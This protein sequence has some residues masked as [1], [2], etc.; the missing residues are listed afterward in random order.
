MAVVVGGFARHFGLDWRRHHTEKETCRK[1]SDKKKKKKKQMFTVF[2]GVQFELDKKY[3]PRDVLGTG[4][5][6]V[7]CSCINLETN[8][9]VA[10]KKIADPFRNP[11][12]ALRTLREAQILRRIGRHDNIISLKDVMLSSSLKDVYLVHELMDYDL[13]RIIKSAPARLSGG[14]V[15]Y[16]L[17]QILRGL[18]FLHSANV[19]HRDLKPQ[20][21]LVNNNWK[22]KICDFGMARTT[23]QDSLVKMTAN[24]GTRSYMAPELVTGAATTWYGNGVDIWSAGCILA[25]MLGGDPMFPSAEPLAVDLLKKMLVVDPL[26]RISASEALEH[27]YFCGVYDPVRDGSA[28]STVTLEVDE[29]PGGVDDKM[30]RDLLWME[31]L[32]YHVE[33]QD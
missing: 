3:A 27:P 16:V 32:F 33:E 8:D 28:P 6:G 7:V 13:G 26:H 18:K 21:I 29:N 23:L 1:L 5:Y 10:I 20:N 11:T 17:F 2:G 4:K 19:V 25:E 14:H 22:L 24:V 30:I 31:M 12:T 9:T 15:K